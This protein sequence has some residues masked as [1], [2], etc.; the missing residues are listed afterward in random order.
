MVLANNKASLEASSQRI[1]AFKTATQ[2][3]P[4]KI[5]QIHPAGS[6]TFGNAFSWKV[7]VG[8]IL[9]QKV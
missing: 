8:K 1:S 2:H 5:F 7:A 9:Q 6:N 4:P 3:F